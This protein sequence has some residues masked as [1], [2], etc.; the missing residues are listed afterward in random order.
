MKAYALPEEALMDALR[1]RAAMTSKNAMAVFR[2]GREVGLCGTR[3][4]AG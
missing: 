1:L 2:S 3:D 4:P